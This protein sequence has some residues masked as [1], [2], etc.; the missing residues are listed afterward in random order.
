[1]QRSHRLL[2]VVARLDCAQG[3]HA[4]PASPHSILAGQSSY[5]NWLR[6]ITSLSQRPAG[7]RQQQD[8]FKQLQQHQRPLPPCLLPQQQQRQLF[9]IGESNDTHK[10]Y[11]ERRLIGYSPKQLYDVVAEVQYYKE[12]VPWCQRSHIMR[13]EGDTFLEAELEVGFRL[14]VERYTSEVYLKPGEQVISKVFDSTLFD[15]LDSTW[16]FKVGPSP[17]STW[18]TFSVDFGFKSPLYRSVA[19]VFFEE[20]VQRMMAAFEGRC[21]VVYGASSLTKKPP[22]SRQV[23]KPLTARA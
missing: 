8:C 13:R 2:H 7:S 22:N 17:S 18:L 16:D 14:F 1:M 9:G 5:C 11:K 3:G 6:S 21:K 10:D 12:F 20:V 4:Q 23:H 15:H 19:A